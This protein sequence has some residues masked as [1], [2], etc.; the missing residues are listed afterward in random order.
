MSTC[1]VGT[2]EPTTMPAT[3]HLGRLCPPYY[4]LVGWAKAAPKTRLMCRPK[5]RRAHAVGS[6]KS[7]ERNVDMRRGHGGTDD[8]ASNMAPRPPLPTLLSARRMGK[9]GPE[10]AFDA[11]SEIPPCPRRRVEQK[12]RAKCRHAAWARRNRRPCQQH[13]TSAA[14]AHPTIS[15]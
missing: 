15:S 2:A 3:W 5:F 6:N 12:C 10:N 4:Q 8:H 14:F 1:G 9:G 13:G 11:P 7:A